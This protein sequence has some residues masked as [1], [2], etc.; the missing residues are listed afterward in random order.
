MK[1]AFGVA[2]GKFLGFTVHKKGIDLDPA[3][4]KATRDMEPS[5]MTKQLKS[6][7]GRTSYIR[8]FILALAKLLEPL[9]RLVKKD[10]PFQWTKEQQVAFQRI[11]DVVGSS[12]TMVSLV[13][14]LPL[15][16]YLTLTN[17]SIGALLT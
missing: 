3:K 1:C 15:T 13:K 11:K 14:G 6:F 17:K 16:M 8:I 9:Q 5:K 4:A 10:A 12:P 2:S 7:L